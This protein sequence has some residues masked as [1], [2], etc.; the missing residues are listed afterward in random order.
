MRLEKKEIEIAGRLAWRFSTNSSGLYLCTRA[1]NEVDTGLRIYQVDECFL[2]RFLDDASSHPLA[3]IGL[4]VASFLQSRATDLERIIGHI[5]CSND[6]TV[7]FIGKY[8]ELLGP[9]VGQRDWT[10]H[11]GIYIPEGRFAIA[12]Y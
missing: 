10:R 3:A 4:S 5:H 11:F 1:G 2:G 9:V 7:P 8:M 12:E 6:D